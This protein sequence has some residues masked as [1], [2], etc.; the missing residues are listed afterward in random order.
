MSGWISSSGVADDLFSLH[1]YCYI[2]SWDIYIDTK[3]S[4]QLLVA[5]TYRSLGMEGYMLT[6]SFPKEW[7]GPQHLV[8]VSNELH[9]L[10]KQTA[11]VSELCGYFWTCLIDAHVTPS[12]AD[13]ASC[14]ES[15]IP[16]ALS[17]HFLAVSFG[18]IFR[19]TF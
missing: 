6:S 19:F 4:Y 14:V 16:P 5:L 13:E 7:I 3:F 11:H 9:P 17:G 10:D 18:G 12:W 15:S 1:P 8:M 2:Y